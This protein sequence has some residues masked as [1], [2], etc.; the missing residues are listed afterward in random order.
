MPAA[1]DLPMDGGCMCRRH[2]YRVEALPLTLY[3]CH[4]ADCQTQSGSAFG[5]SMTVARQAFTMR[6][7]P[8]ALERP[9]DSGRMVRA[10]FC[11]QCGTRLFHEPSRA[12]EQVNIKAG[13]LDDTSWVWPV[14]HLWLKSAQP[15]FTPPADALRFD[16]QPED[17]TPM[18]ERFQALFLPRSDAASSA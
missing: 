14:A 18:N 4:C 9:A 7:E 16:D 5:L 3:A 10:R 11:D 13:T 15:W 2:R 12:T 6:G 1:P 17:R 8:A